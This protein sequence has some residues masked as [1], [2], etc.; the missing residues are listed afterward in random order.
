VGIESI[1]LSLHL[2]ADC[3]RCC[4]LKHS[5]NT[6]WV[7]CCT[8]L[9]DSARVEEKGLS[10]DIFMTASMSTVQYYLGFRYL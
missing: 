7:L 2:L 6:K 5:V 3:R 9:R 4:F 8:V 10:L 1:I